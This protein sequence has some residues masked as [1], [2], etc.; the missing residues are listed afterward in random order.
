MDVSQQLHDE[1]GLPRPEFFRE[2]ALHMSKAGYDRWIPV[3]RQA[4][5]EMF[6]ETR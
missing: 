2:D 3:L 5:S 1:Q 4:L 6:Q